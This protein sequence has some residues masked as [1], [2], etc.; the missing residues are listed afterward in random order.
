M[1]IIIPAAA[2][3]GGCKEYKYIHIHT[4]CSRAGWKKQSTCT[5]LPQQSKVGEIEYEYIPA[6]AEQVGCKVYKYIRTC[7][8]RAGWEK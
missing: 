2:E 3:Q 1:S 6:A 5:Y 4:C 8:S 7:C